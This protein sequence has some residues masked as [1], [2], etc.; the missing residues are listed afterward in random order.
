MLFFFGCSEVNSS[1]LITSELA[2]QPARKVL[3]SCVVYTNIFQYILKQWIA[4]M[5]RANWLVKLRI[6]CA[7]YL[8]A[9]QEK[10]AS[11]LHS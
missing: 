10:M 1:S 4:L 3:F 7:I 8:R 2:N 9:T 5:A 6:S 11:G